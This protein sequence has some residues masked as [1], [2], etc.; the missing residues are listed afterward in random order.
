MGNT[1]KT[2]EASSGAFCTRR[3]R[4][5]IADLGSLSEADLQAI[6]V[7]R[8]AIADTVADLLVRQGCDRPEDVH[9]RNDQEGEMQ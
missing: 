6:G 9:S 8:G 7:W 5:L 4:A 1:A 2:N 3:R